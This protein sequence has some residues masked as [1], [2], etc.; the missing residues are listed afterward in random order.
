[1]SATAGPDISESGLVL[2]LDAGNSRSYPSS[3]T[4]WNDISGNNNSGTLTNGPTFSSNNL[5]SIAFNSSSLQYVNIANPTVFDFANTTFTTSVWV[6]T[7]S[8]ATQLI[9]TKGYT[10]GGWTIALQ[11]DGTVEVGTKNNTTGAT[12]CGRASVAVINDNMWH[13]ISAICTTSTTVV[14]SNDIQIYIDGILNQGAITK[15]LT[16]STEAANLNIGRRSIG[17][18]FTGNVA[19]LQIWNR[20]LSPQEILQNFNA[21]RSRFGV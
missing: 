6:K 2:Y 7:I 21:Q 11:P 4:T 8:T 15:S 9:I 19:N 13:C 14:N 18:Y 3:G 5:G 16:Y 1:M 12:A 17:L 10:S 20:A